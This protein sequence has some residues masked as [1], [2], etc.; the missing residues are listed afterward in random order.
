MTA[1]IQTT[2]RSARNFVAAVVD[3]NDFVSGAPSRGDFAGEFLPH[4]PIRIGKYE[5][6][7]DGRVLD[8]R[9]VSQFGQR[10][11]RQDRARRVFC[12][13]EFSVHFVA[14]LKTP[15]FADEQFRDLPAPRHRQQFRTRPAHAEIRRDQRHCGDA[16]RSARLCRRVDRE[17]CSGRGGNDDDFLTNLTA[18]RQRLGIVVDPVVDGRGSHRRAVLPMSI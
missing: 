12:G 5:Q 7:G 10:R 8:R 11:H 14:R 13:P 2:I 6:S 3:W 16:F 18:D 9:R 15:L 17:R 4:D 1:L